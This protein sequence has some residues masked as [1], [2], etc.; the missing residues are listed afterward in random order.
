[1]AERVRP[2]GAKSLWRSAVQQ[3]T[4]RVL[5]QGTASLLMHNERLVNPFDP[6]TKAIATIT[7]KRSRQTDE[8]RKQVQRLEWEGGLYW[9]KEMGPYMP[10]ANIKRCIMEA[11]TMYK[12]GTA[13]KRALT[14]L[15]TEVPLLYEGPRDLEGLWVS[16]K[17]VDVRSVK[18]NGRTRI[19]RTRPKFY[20]WGLEATM[21]L[22]LN[23][24]SYD[25]F[26]HFVEEAGLTTGLGDYRPTFGRF[27][28]QIEQI[29]EEAAA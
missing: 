9:S 26:E 19:M 11:A 18:L 1:M 5:I 17:Y 20:D 27:R 2:E 28:A 23:A 15:D 21:R 22:N 6:L 25:D 10:T 4:V 8:D 16:E 13:V 24:L 7:A 12:G 14:P 3:V 29:P